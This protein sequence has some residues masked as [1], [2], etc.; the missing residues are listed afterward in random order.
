[1]YENLLHQDVIARQLKRDIEHSTLPPAMLFSGP[2]MSGKLTAA[3]ETA[4]ILSCRESGNWACHCAMCRQHR[5]LM[6]PRTVIAGSRV[7]S[8]EIAASADVLRRHVSDTSRYLMVRSIGKLLRR[9]DPLLWEGEEMRIAQ[10]R[11]I[12]VRLSEN[13]DSLT[14]GRKLPEGRLFIKLLDTLIDDCRTLQ[15]ALPRVLPVYQIRHL[16]NWALHTAG[17]DYKTI[18][19][20]SADRMPMATT[21]ALLKFLEEPPPETTVILITNRKTLMLSTVI[22]RLRVC[23]FT[24]RT[25]SQ[26]ASIIDRVFKAGTTQY[27]NLRDFFQTWNL[28]TSNQIQNLAEIFI[29]GA[30]NSYFS[31]ELLSIKDQT[32]LSILFDAIN[33]L[34]H[35]RWEKSENISLRIRHRQLEHIRVARSRA[36]YLNIPVYPILRTLQLQLGLP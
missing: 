24:A 1:M 28:E 13:V 10:F 17:K 4:R 15:K 20:D 26:E 14:P 22:S 23:S 27:G 29:N 34:L 12:M 16:I 33:A 7:L 18:I 35:E 8:L 19:I 21:N 30:Q 3:L 31:E 5:V 6:H 9:F 11:Q 32:D 36:E 2:P 25:D